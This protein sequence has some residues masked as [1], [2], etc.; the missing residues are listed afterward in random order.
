[1]APDCFACM[2][3]ECACCT[4]CGRGFCWNHGQGK[5]RPLICDDC[6]HEWASYKA[7]GPTI[8]FA[9]ILIGVIL[10]CMR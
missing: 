10:A 6:W 5:P 3:E 8:L 1:M 7:I 4:R 9:I 2:S